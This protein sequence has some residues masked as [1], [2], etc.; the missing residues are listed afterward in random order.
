MYAGTSGFAFLQNVNDGGQP[1]AIMSSLD[2]SIEFF[3]WRM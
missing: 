1:I 2:R 3:L